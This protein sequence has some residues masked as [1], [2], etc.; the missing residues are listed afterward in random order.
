MLVV[1]LAPQLPFISQCRVVPHR[2][3][4]SPFSP[5]IYLLAVG[6]EEVML[7][8][9]MSPHQRGTVTTISKGNGHGRVFASQQ[10]LGT[11]CRMYFLKVNSRLFLTK[12]LCSFQ[13]NVWL[14]W[15]CGRWRTEQLIM[16]YKAQSDLNI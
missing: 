16:L 12:V 7:S 13:I 4:W 6:G 8:T 15:R 11:R 5:G 10:A 3:R 14:F 2:D 9:Q 1:L